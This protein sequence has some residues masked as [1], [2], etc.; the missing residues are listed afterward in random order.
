MMISISPGVLFSFW[1]LAYIFS[2]RWFPWRFFFFTQVAGAIPG[3]ARNF[4]PF[5][6]A[7]LVFFPDVIPLFF[8][9]VC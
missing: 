2:Q 6:K 5:T 3:F 4:T 1:V 7:S 9:C 8:Y